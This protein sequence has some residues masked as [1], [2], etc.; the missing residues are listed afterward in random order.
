MWWGVPTSHLLGESESETGKDWVDIL[1]DTVRLYHQC[2]IR[3]DVIIPCEVSLMKLPTFT[4]SLWDNG[5]LDLDIGAYSDFIFLSSRHSSVPSMPGCF[6]E[7]KNS[8][9]LIASLDTS[10]VL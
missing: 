1:T 7:R 2:L 4:N 9:P 6:S 5:K 10:I 8:T 3:Y